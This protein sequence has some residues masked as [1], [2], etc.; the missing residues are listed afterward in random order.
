ML[1]SDDRIKKIEAASKHNRPFRT[2]L[3][4]TRKAVGTSEGAWLNEFNKW[5]SSQVLIQILTLG[6]KCLTFPWHVWLQKTPVKNLLQLWGIVHSICCPLGLLS[7][8]TTFEI[9]ASRISFASDKSM[10]LLVNAQRLWYDMIFIKFTYSLVDLFIQCLRILCD[11]A[12]TNQSGKVE[13]QGAICH[14]LVEL[15]PI[16]ALALHFFALFHLS[17]NEIYDWTP[18]FSPESQAAGYGQYGRHE[19]HQY[20]VFPGESKTRSMKYQ[21]ILLIIYWSLC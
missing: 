12:K 19:W 16:G 17:K 9:C 15:C 8:V 21:S 18:D 20:K 14:R 10:S 7:V 3:S 13:E 2:L 4:Q 1:R 11:N 5:C 6:N